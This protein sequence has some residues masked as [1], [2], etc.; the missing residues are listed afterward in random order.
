ML[1][2]FVQADQQ[3]SLLLMVVSCYQ[4][5]RTWPHMHTGSAAKATA[6]EYGNTLEHANC[7][8]CFLTNTRMHHDVQPLF[9]QQ[10]HLKTSDVWLLRLACTRPGR[11]RHP[12][13]GP[14]PAI[15]GTLAEMTVCCNRLEVKGSRELAFFKGKAEGPVY[16]GFC[17]ESEA[18]A[19]AAPIAF[20]PLSSSSDTSS[21]AAG[22]RE[23]DREAEGGPSSLRPTLRSSVPQCDDITEALRIPPR[24]G[25]CLCLGCLWVLAIIHMYT[26]PQMLSR[27]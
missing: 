15:V 6:A 11:S 5:I 3:Q 26:L 7:T 20:R 22:V 12:Q 18:G 24:V 17:Y 8:S 27:C 21:P 9:F 14:Q 16:P 10:Q 25:W 13:V 1:S 2:D 19:H 4:A 23:P